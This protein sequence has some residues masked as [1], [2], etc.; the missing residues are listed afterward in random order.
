MKRLF[1]ILAILVAGGTAHAAEFQVAPADHPLR[2]DPVRIALV[3]APPN[4][5]IEISAERISQDGAD[6]IKSVAR[7]RADAEGRVDLDDS[8]SLGGSYVGVDASGLFWSMTP[9]PRP[10]DA[11]AVPNRVR[12]RA[13][14][15]GGGRFAERTIDFE[16]GSERLIETSAPFPGAFLLTPRG[17]RRRPTLILL[18]G[19]EGGAIFAR[20]IGPRLAA[21][22]YAVLGLPYWNAPGLPQTFEDIPVD[23]LNQVHDW[24]ARQPQVDPTHIGLV[25][26]SKGA[27]FT[28]LAASLFPW[29][30]AAVAYAPSDVVWEG[31][32]GASP[33]GTHSSFDWQGKP[34]PF[35]AYEGL[36][37]ARAR[38]VNGAPLDL[39]GTM[40]RARQ[41]RSAVERARIHIEN[42][43]GRLPLIAGEDDQV[44]PCAD[45]ARAIARR[46][47]AAGL[48]TETRIYAGA[49]HYI[50]GDGFAAVYSG[51]ETGGLR[52][53]NALARRDGWA[54]TLA[55]LD[56]WRATS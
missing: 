17:E 48:A 35:L 5:L 38:A 24:L 16:T 4:A 50:A 26:V 36:D 34:L 6:W 15:V 54:A 28:V 18:G 30:S 46:R 52:P 1:L 47:L 55:F 12:L 31:F 49:G 32:G 43:R 29:V 19:S 37:A 14:I 40:V 53:R 51:D 21:H 20:D 25:G 44:C 13:Q 10:N 22:G 3:A 56:R 7:Y 45:M 39:V 27:E 8:P 2:S 23:R 33:T 9:S 42:Y 41:D 11:Q